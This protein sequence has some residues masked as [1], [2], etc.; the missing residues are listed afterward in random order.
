MSRKL[1]TIDLFAETMLDDTYKHVVDWNSQ[2]ELDNYL[3]S[4][5]EKITMQGSYQNITRPVRWNSKQ[6]T[7]NELTK[8][9]YIRI[10]NVD[11]DG[12]TKKYYG[13]ITN[14]EYV[15]DGCTFIYYSIDMWNTYKFEISTNKAMIERAFVQEFKDNYSDWTDDFLLVKNNSE[16]IGGDGAL[17]LITSSNCVFSAVDGQ[18]GDYILDGQVKFIVFTCQPEDVQ[19]DK[20]SLLGVYSQYKYYVLAYDTK[21]G[22]TLSFQD[23]N[24]K[25]ILE[26]GEP[27]SDIYN[28]ISA[29]S[30]LAGSSS[31]VVD[32]EILDYIGLDFTSVLTNGTVTA[33]KFKKSFGYKAHD[34][35]LEINDASTE[36][37]STQKGILTNDKTNI[38]SFVNIADY[39]QQLLNFRFASQL[40]VKNIPFKCIANPFAKLCFSDGKGNMLMADFLKFNRLNMQ[41]I[42]LQRFGGITENSKIGYALNNYNRATTEDQSALVTYENAMII[43]DSANDTPLILDNYTMY[44]NS[45]RNQLANSRANAKMNLQ[46]SKEGNLNSLNNLSRSQQAQRTTLG[47]EQANEQNNFK[48]NTMANLGMS[49]VNAGVGMAFNPTLS[50]VVGGVLGLAGAGVSAYAQNRTMNNNQ[51]TARSVQAVNQNAESANARV[52]YAYANKVATNNYEQTIRS[53]NAMLADVKNQNDVIA[54][55]GTNASW[56]MQNN[57]SQLHGQIFFSQDA[58]M[59]NVA[60]YFLL[61]GYAINLYDD[62]DNYRKR[63]NVFNY[64]RTSNA[65]VTGEV[66]QAVI[67]T[68]NSMFDNGVT[69]WNSSH[70]DDFVNREYRNNEFR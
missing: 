33:I 38:K 12:N 27:V 62:I 7:F 65:Q 34:N 69:L 48:F 52:N 21:S 59:L 30:A 53:Q 47:M 50:G 2:D 57:N 68:F 60:L 31:R 13:F 63:K 9:S 8:Y 37:F 24:G 5:H 42:V 18:D 54:H 58:V 43:D 55:Q 25:T 17:H 6:V 19:K 1:A 67:N 11:P 4:G 49:A 35:Y 39:L 29:D 15:N 23:K 28:N 56:D 14:L 32:A 46:L 36:K 66:N 64:I 70:L 41:N 51:A 26:M 44:L 20:G 3:D 10:T 16:E 45:N 61:F 40:G 22:N